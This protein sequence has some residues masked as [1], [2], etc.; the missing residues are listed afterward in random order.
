MNRNQSLWLAV[1]C[2][3]L[4]LIGGAALRIGTA[5]GPLSEQVLPFKMS[6]YIVPMGERWRLRWASPYKPGE[7]QPTYEIRTSQRA[8][9]LGCLGK[10]QAVAYVKEPGQTGLLDLCAAGGEAVIWLGEGTRF[11]VANDR[12]EVTASIFHVKAGNNCPSSSTQ[13]IQN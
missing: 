6:G 8:I 5:M 9:K 3:L 13:S 10:I 12:I 11:E 2:F 1:G 4:G 7:I